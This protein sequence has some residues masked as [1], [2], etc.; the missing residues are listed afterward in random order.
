MTTTTT[1][2]T[3]CCSFCSEPGHDIRSC[4][5]IRISNCWRDI[6]CHTYIESGAFLSDED[7][8]NVNLYI[9]TLDPHLVR[10]VAVQMGQC[11]SR[12]S[13]ET[14]I[15]HICMS[16]YLEAARFEHL[17]LEE[18]REFLHWMDPENYPLEVIPDTSDEFDDLPDLISDDDDDDNQS[19]HFIEPLLL[20][21]ESIE[22]LGKNSECPICFE[23]ETNLLDMDTTACEH[24][25]C[26]S[27]ITKHLQTNP[28][29]PM[30]RAPVK[31][32]QVRHK[33][34][35]D[36]I[37]KMFGTIPVNLHMEA[38]RHLDNIIGIR[39][40]PLYVIGRRI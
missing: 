28:N 31:T 26:H 23:E 5:D 17:S 10:G 12:D 22:E 20:C 38:R 21:L 7:L 14:Q 27:C 16:I 1:T 29:C 25:F 3:R 18:K 11:R 13:L 30:C 34:N 2:T 35:Y 37:R 4:T 8:E 33:D 32:L 39:R 40:I 9:R 24:S 36:E 15:N 19:L 6:L